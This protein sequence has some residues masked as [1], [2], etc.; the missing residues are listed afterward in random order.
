M[1]LAVV[2]VSVGG[3]GVGTNEYDELPENERPS[4]SLVKFSAVVLPDTTTSE[5]ANIRRNLFL[6]RDFL[7][8]CWE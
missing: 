4:T 7:A 6:V 3:S 2:L 1:G 5:P 8:T